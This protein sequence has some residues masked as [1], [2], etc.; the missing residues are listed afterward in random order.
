MIFEEIVNLTSFPSMVAEA[1]FWV[2]W[3]LLRESTAFLYDGG[4]SLFSKDFLPAA[5]RVFIASV[6]S[7]KARSLSSMLLNTTENICQPSLAGNAFQPMACD[8]DASV[9]LALNLS[10]VQGPWVL[11]NNFLLA[12]FISSS[13]AFSLPPP[14]SSLRTRSL[15]APTDLVRVSAVIQN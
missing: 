8:D 1:A 6:E 13:S 4:V 11:K 14:V 3:I 9:N 15:I 10:R 12:E 7:K 5:C 2:A